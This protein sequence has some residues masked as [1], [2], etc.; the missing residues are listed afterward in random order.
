VH[1]LQEPQIAPPVNEEENTTPAESEQKQDDND[2]NA[3]IS[4]A[5]CLGTIA[6][7]RAT[8][9]PQDVLFWGSSC[10]NGPPALQPSRKA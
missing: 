7:A 5:C 8:N 1:F 9:A 2:D 10:K 6:S 3:G 4:A